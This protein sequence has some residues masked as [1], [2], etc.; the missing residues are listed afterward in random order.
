[1]IEFLA[2]VATWTLLWFAKE[3]VLTGVKLAHRSWETYR[4][5]M[6]E[7]PDRAKA[8]VRMMSEVFVTVAMVLGVLSVAWLCFGLWWN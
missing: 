2:F 1:M 7:V 4:S 6:I 3:L 8:W 5:T